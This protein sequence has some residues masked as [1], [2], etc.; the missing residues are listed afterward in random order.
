MNFYVNKTGFVWKS[1]YFKNF[2]NYRVYFTSYTKCPRHENNLNIPSFFN[3]R[4]PIADNSLPLTW[5][6]GPIL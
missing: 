6:L 1:M 4:H 3:K 2:L 5:Q